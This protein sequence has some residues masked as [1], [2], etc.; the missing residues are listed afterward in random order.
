M[1][2]HKAAEVCDEEGIEHNRAIQLSAELDPTVDDI[3]VLQGQEIFLPDVK[4]YLLDL[5]F[6][7]IEGC[8]YAIF[9]WSHLKGV[10]EATQFSHTE[11]EEGAGTV[12]A[13]SVA[14]NRAVVFE[15]LL[16]F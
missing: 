4:E 15:H 1:L 10:L 13:V 2:M 12:K 5:E 16:Q 14:A 7:Q 6:L 11:V 3:H 9:Y 8:F